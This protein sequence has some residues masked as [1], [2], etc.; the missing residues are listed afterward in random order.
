MGIRGSVG[1]PGQ[2][3]GWRKVGK[4]AQGRALEPGKR[5]ATGKKKQKV[6]EGVGGIRVSGPL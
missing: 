4:E 5:A 6:T 3:A 2:I 1:C